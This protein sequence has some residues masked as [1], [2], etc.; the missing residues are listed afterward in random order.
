M[1]VSKPPVRQYPLTA[2]ITGFFTILGF[3]MASATCGPTL[4]SQRSASV[5]GA[6]IPVRIGMAVRRSIPE[7]KMSGRQE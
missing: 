2:A 6:R 7:Q 4:D 5:S 3:S 1:I